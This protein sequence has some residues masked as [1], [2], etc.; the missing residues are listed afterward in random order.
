[1]RISDWSSDVCSSDRQN[2][3]GVGAGVVDR[4]GEGLAVRSDARIRNTG[5]LAGTVIATREG[6]QIRLDQVAQV[7][8]GQ[9]IRYGSAS[10]NGKEVVVGT[11]VMRIGE[12]SRTVASA[13][14]ARLDE[15][16]ASLP[17]DGGVQ[18]VLDRTSMVN[19]T[20]KTVSKKLIEGALDRQSTRLNYSN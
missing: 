18:P 17:T 16:N 8:L 19:S 13:V 5:E 1:M 9:A 10:E 20:I 4:G 12:N 15:I 11:A 3:V 6:V 2:N 14:A 7:R